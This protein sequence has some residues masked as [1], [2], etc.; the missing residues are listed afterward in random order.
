M[1]P[2]KEMMSGRRDSLRSSRIRERFMFRAFL[3]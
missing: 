3:E 1:P 2:A